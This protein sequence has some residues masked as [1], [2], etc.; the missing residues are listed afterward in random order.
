MQAV[1]FAPQGL[2][3]R[4]YTTAL[5]PQ[6]FE[7]SYPDA[8]GRKNEILSGGLFLQPTTATPYQNFWVRYGA[9]WFGE[10]NYISWRSNDRY[11]RMAGVSVGKPFASLF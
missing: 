8:F 4:S 7:V 11:A 5:A 2:A 9:G 10:V 1:T 6:G 3:R